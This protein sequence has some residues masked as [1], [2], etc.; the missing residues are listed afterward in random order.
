MSKRHDA[1]GEEAAP[2]R[3]APIPSALA[4][5]PGLGDVRR[6]SHGVAGRDRETRLLVW[7]EGLLRLARNEDL[8]DA[9][10][11][12]ARA[13]SHLHDL[14]GLPRR[15]LPGCHAEFSLGRPH[16]ARTPD[17]ADR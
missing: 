16:V 8:Q 4:G 15:T 1:V 12:A 9:R 13:L 2:R 10:A 17:A 6:A 14:P 5:G 7:R 3:E 11:G